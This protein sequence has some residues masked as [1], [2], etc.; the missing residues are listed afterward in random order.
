M[1]GLDPLLFLSLKPCV[2]PAIMG[3]RSYIWYIEQI[4]LGEMQA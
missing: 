2:S 4:E 1:S 3:P